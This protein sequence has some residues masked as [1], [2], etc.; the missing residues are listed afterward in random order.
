MDAIDTLNVKFDKFRN[1]DS[2][3]SEPRA[4]L[5]VQHATAEICIEGADLLTRDSTLPS[6]DPAGTL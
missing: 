1:R 4:P 3:P 5:T 2:V 6:D